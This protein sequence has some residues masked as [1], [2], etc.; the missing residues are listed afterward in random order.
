MDNMKSIL[1]WKKRKQLAQMIL[2]AAAYTTGDVTMLTTFPFVR[3][4]NTEAQGLA[5]IK[6]KVIVNS[7]F[8]I[9]DSLFTIFL[10]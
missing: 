5:L 2:T 3:A 9:Y 4:S 6:S 10:R 1:L 8:E 7:H